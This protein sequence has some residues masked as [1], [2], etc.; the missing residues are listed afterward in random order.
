MTKGFKWLF[1]HVLLIITQVFVIRKK[2][3]MI[4]KNIIDL[5]IIGVTGIFGFIGVNFFQNK[6]FD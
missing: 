4:G 2:G 1:L 6:F 5:A 3:L